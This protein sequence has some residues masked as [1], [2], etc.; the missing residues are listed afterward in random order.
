MV[1]VSG[2]YSS[3]EIWLALESAYSHDSMERSQN[4]KDSLRQLKKGTLSV[5]E[6]AKQFKAICD[7]LSAIGQTVSNDDK[8]H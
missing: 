7:Q 2:L 1:E 3:R 6:F 8:S 4:L 5:S